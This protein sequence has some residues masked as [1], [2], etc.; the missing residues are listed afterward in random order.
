MSQRTAILAELR[1]L[2]SEVSRIQS[3]L[4][5]L[6]AN[7]EELDFELVGSPPESSS[8]GYSAGYQSTP[9][10]KQGP[11]A[12]SQSAP[13]ASSAAQLSDA[14]R[15]S[16]AGDTGRFF[17][18]CLSGEP[19]G[20]SGQG[21]IKLQKRVYVVIRTFTGRVHT[22]PVLVFHS[23]ADTKAVVADPDTGEFGDSIFA[24]FA[25]QWE[26]KVAV[27]QAGYLWPESN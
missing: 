27:A 7:L 6:V 18:R 24:G 17:V 12:G 23:F 11:I 5:E 20:V 10:T 25:A 15:R 22:A 1:G 16:I 8:S 13:P 4:T 26:A 14:D 3:R 9:G 21:R 19:R 2:Q